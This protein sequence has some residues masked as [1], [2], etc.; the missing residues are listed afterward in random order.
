MRNN[1]IRFQLEDKRRKL[2]LTQRQ[3]AEQLGLP[4]NTYHTYEAGRALP[5]GER[6]TIIEEWLNS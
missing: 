1:T 4:V 2:G 3:M 6:K 5:K